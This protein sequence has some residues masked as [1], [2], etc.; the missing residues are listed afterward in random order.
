VLK[1]SKGSFFSTLRDKLMW[2]ADSRE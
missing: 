2:G 1:R